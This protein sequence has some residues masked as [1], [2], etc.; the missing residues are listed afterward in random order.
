LTASDLLHSFTQRSDTL[1]YLLHLLIHQR[2]RY[3]S[4]RYC[5]QTKIVGYGTSTLPSN[6]VTWRISLKRCSNSR[7]KKRSNS[8]QDLNNARASRRAAM[9][10]RKSLLKSGTRLKR[11]VRRVSS[12]KHRRVMEWRNHQPDA[13][14]LIPGLGSA[15]R[16][17]GAKVFRR[18]Y[19]LRNA[20]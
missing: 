13:R 18:F 14:R 11:A 12:P 7:Q 15:S 5:R 1:S 20:A 10:R 9:A 8:R 17:T 2:A 19:I 16:L 4:M 6:G 3:R